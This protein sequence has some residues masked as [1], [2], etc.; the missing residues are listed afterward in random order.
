MKVIGM[1]CKVYIEDGLT[2]KILA[3]QR[4]ATLSRADDLI[5]STS[6]NVGS[7]WIDCD[8]AFVQDDDAYNALESKFINSE[9]VNVVISFPS[10]VIYRGSTAITEFRLE[11]P[12]D[13][14]VTYSITLQGNRPLIT[15]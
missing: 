13:E 14:L 8:G 4:N 3:G 5:D 1:K 12:Y 7:Y 10:G 6:K 9:N 15:V 2:G 11:L